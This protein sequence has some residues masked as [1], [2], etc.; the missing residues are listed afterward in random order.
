MAN[1]PATAKLIGK[2][3]VLFFLDSNQY[4]RI[5]FPIWKIL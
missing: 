4:C 2:A 1:D 3:R 5:I